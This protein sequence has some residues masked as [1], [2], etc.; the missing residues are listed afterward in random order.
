MFPCGK[1]PELRA[2]AGLDPA[3]CMT[4]HIAAL[5]RVHD[6]L[7]SSHGIVHG[8]THSALSV[9]FVTVKTARE[10]A[11]P[12]RNSRPITADAPRNLTPH[13]Q[14]HV[15]GGA[16][17]PRDAFRAWPVGL[18]PT[19]WRVIDGC[20][21]VAAPPRLGG[22]GPVLEPRPTCDRQRRAPLL[23]LVISQ[24]GLTARRK[25]PHKHSCLEARAPG[26]ELT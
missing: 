12:G 23:S 22:D 18:R 13:N 6:E 14:P 26:A 5:P 11:S 7:T 25:V 21:R 17:L 10:F 19:R 9:G 16:A 15:T 3:A 4:A 2:L 24:R 8:G 1:A 20:L